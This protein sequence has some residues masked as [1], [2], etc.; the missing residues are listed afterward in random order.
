[1]LVTY[2]RGKSIFDGLDTETFHETT[3]QSCFKN[4]PVFYIFLCDCKVFGFFDVEQVKLWFDEVKE[5]PSYILALL[6][7]GLL[8]LDL[9]VP[10]PSLTICVLSGYFGSW[11]GLA[12][13][14]NDRSRTVCI[15]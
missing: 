1:M 14:G 9:F 4:R 15:H 2:F 11:V 8:F 13:L 10:V 3:H 12:C 7:I 5:K 6:P